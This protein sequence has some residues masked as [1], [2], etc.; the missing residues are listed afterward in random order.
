[1][2]Y[3]DKMS[4]KQWQVAESIRRRLGAVQ[5]L[6]TLC[7]DD[8]EDAQPLYEKLPSTN[9][10]GGPVVVGANIEILALEKNILYLSQQ[11]SMILHE[12][13][14]DNQPTQRT[15]PYV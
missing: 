14:P 13:I 7:I 9:I 2:K 5:L 12:A 8:L 15:T 11:V 10:S 6:L 1:M 4:P 3:Q